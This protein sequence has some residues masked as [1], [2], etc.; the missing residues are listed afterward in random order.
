MNA[1]ESGAR[2]AIPAVLVYGRSAGRVLMIRRGAEA[3][4]RADDYH[5]GKWNGL[6]GKL[7]PGESPLEAAR[8]EF[9]EESG[10]DL[11]EGA[12]RAL[13]VIHFP[14]FKAHKNEDW[15]VYLFSAEVPSE[16]AGALRPQSEEGSL[17][18]IASAEVAAL[19]LWPGDSLFLP[20]ALAGKPV[21]GTIWYE[22][23]EVRRHWIQPL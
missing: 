21:A 15:I 12:F 2:K 11:P 16:R 18:W 3:G 8:R 5:S 13:G 10:I 14:N 19:P 1:F 17:H 22:G 23:Q 6:G 9:R 20:L 7:E 4:G